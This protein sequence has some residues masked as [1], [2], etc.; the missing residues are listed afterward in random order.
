[1]APKSIVVF[2]IASL[3]STATGVFH[4]GDETA[5]DEMPDI[6]LERPVVFG[7]VPDTEYTKR[8]LRKREFSGFVGSQSEDCNYAPVFSLLGGH[9][10]DGDFPVYY[11][12]ESF[13]ELRGGQR[14]PPRGALAGT[15]KDYEGYL[16][17]SCSYLPTSRAKFCQD[18]ADGRVYIVF[19]SAPPNCMPVK[20]SIIDD[21]PATQFPST[22]LTGGVEDYTWIESTFIPMVSSPGPG[23]FS[24]ST[25]TTSTELLTASLFESSD[26]VPSVI[27]KPL[28]DALVIELPSSIPLP[29]DLSKNTTSAKEFDPLLQ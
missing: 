16:R 20:L 23:V 9:L 14:S 1:M 28:R 24:P 4:Y 22:S 5:A 8:G 2:L 21:L 12:F 13:K 10:L 15:F 7:I 17:F 29:A 19:T 27:M 3:I 25:A 11:D 6:E 18:L 26:P